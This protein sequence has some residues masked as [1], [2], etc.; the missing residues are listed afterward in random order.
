MPQ[1]ARYAQQ[2]PDPWRE[3]ESVVERL[4]RFVLHAHALVERSRLPEAD[5]ADRPRPAAPGAGTTGAGTCGAGTS[6]PTGAGPGVVARADRRRRLEAGLELARKALHAAVRV[7][8]DGRLP[9]P[10]H[11]ADVGGLPAAPVPRSGQLT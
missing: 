5:P 1:P 2:G 11:P 3:L 9:G 8:A 6:G 10:R 7:D 4:A